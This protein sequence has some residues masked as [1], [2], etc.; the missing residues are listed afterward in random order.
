MPASHHQPLLRR[1]FASTTPFLCCLST[2]STRSI[3]LRISLKMI[4]PLS[5]LP[6]AQT[7]ARA[8]LFMRTSAL[9]LIS[10]GRLSAKYLKAPLLRLP[11]QERTSLEDQLMGLTSRTSDGLC[12]PP[13]G[14]SSLTSAY[15]S[16]LAPA[17]IRAVCK[18]D[19][20]CSV[21]VAEGE[22]VAMTATCAAGDVK[23][24]I[25]TL[26]SWEL[27]YGTCTCFPPPECRASSL[28]RLR[29]R[30]HSR[31]AYSEALISA[32]SFRA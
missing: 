15:A 11:S 31:S 6:P 22:T 27:R 25:S 30:M 4:V 12:A 16:L 26:V 32:P 29:R 24:S 21:S 28:C 2:L 5:W 17:I 13:R 19:M 23:H 14:T 8:A 9:P 3:S 20:V 7:C 18:V 1:V 10:G